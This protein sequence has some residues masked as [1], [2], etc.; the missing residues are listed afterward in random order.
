MPQNKPVSLAC[1]EQWQRLKML[2]SMSQTELR[3]L[4]EEAFFDVVLTVSTKRKQPP[5][6]SKKLIRGS[7]E[8]AESDA[9]TDDIQSGSSTLLHHMKNTDS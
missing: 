4:F 1:V 7:A 6:E 5:S 9:L 8:V 2:H 3:R